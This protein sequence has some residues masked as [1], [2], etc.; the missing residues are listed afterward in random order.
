MLAHATTA[1][2]RRF[3]KAH[4]LTCEDIAVLKAAGIDEV[5]A[6]ILSAGR[7]RRR[8]GAATRLAESMSFRGI[9]AK[10]AATGRVNLHARAAGVF[11]VDKA[12]I[13]RVNAIDPAITVATVAEHE[14]VEEGQM[15][16][17]VKI[18]PFGVAGKLV[19][20]AVVD[21]G[22]RRRFSPSIRS[23]RCGSA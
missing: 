19:D 15:V 11:T 20:A 3:R 21:P 6:A 14:A 9:E 2:E 7:S 10:P 13:D 1:G 22:G 8:P 12:M 5:V 23:G 17:T 4:V 18:I 16:A